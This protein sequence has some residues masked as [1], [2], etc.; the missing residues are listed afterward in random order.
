MFSCR[1]ADA[2]GGRSEVTKGRG[3]ILDT[4]G[5]SKGKKRNV[6]LGFRIGAWDAPAT[7]R[8]QGVLRPG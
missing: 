2:V 5:Y 4:N 8:W 7:L 1:R 6:Y 3:K